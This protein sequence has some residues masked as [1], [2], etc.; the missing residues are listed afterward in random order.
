MDVKGKDKAIGIDLGISCNCIEVWQY[1]RVEIIVNNQGLV[2]NGGKYH[3]AT[4][5]HNTIFNVKILIGR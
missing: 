2:G 1:D 3:I 4:K 5:P